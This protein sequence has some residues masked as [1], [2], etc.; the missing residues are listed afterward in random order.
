MEMTYICIFLAR[1]NLFLFLKY[2][3]AQHLAAWNVTNSWIEAPLAAHCASVV[4]KN[5]Q[6]WALL[7][8]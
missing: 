8:H 1:Y 7:M 6:H 2:F 3:A 5:L 4:Q